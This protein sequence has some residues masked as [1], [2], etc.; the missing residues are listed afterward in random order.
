MGAH[1]CSRCIKGGSHI[2][3]YA[4]KIGH[5][6]GI[7]DNW[8]ECS[9]SIKGFSGAEYK[10]FPSR[11]EADAYL[12]NID[13]WGDKIKDDINQG[14]IVAFCDGSY[15]DKLKR[16]SYGVLLV[17]DNLKESEICGF[18]S[19]PK[20]LSSRNVIGEIFGV[21]NA[22]DWAVS[23]GFHKIK[24]YH[25]YEGLGKWLSGE[26]RAESDT[27]KMFVA[28]F[29]SKYAD[30]M[31]VDFEKVKGHSNNQY[32]D[33]A[34][35]LAKKALV[36]RTKLAIQGDNWFTLPHFDGNEL[37][38]VISLLVEEHHG[39]QIDKSES[40]LKVIYKL[41]LNKDKVVITLFKSGNRKILVQGANSLLLQMIISFISE[42]VGIDKIEPILSSAYRVTID[43]AKISAS[44]RDICPELPS[45]YPDN[46]KRL[47]KQAII[48]MNYYIKSEEYSQYAFPALRALE[49]HMKYIFCK[50]G[51]TVSKTFQMFEFNKTSNRYEL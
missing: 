8:P 15:D 26:W 44:F 29:Q 50:A 20:Y 11:E 48:N 47:I 32:N 40:A 49:G 4:V 16:Y 45:D 23:N 28:I 17:Y 5:T 33:K 35:E 1:N 2:K 19:N 13:F 43:T 24:I 10:S 18:G 6:T 46:I 51:V 9:E 30:I 31:Q 21:I 39:T 12:G 7:F 41:K 34:D 25:D 37:Q 22:L 42:L 14:Y 27:A 36:D 38:A 3:Y